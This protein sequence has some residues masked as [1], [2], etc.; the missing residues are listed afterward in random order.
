MISIALF[1]DFLTNPSAQACVCLFSTFMPSAGARCGSHWARAAQGAPIK[2]MPREHWTRPVIPR[3]LQAVQ[4]ILL[5]Q[6]FVCSWE[7]FVKQIWDTSTKSQ[8]AATR[9][10]TARNHTSKTRR[11]RREPRRRPVATI[12]AGTKRATITRKEKNSNDRNPRES[13][14]TNVKINENDSWS[15]SD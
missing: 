1:L 2:G 14:A 12:A 6:L 9:M 5:Y 11:K 10:A 15:N 4:Y 7:H 3:H 8:K 13:L